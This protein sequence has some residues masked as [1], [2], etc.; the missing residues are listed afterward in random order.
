MNLLPKCSYLHVLLGHLVLQ[1]LD[2]LHHNDQLSILHLSGPLL[3]LLHLLLHLC[4]LR[5]GKPTPKDGPVDQPLLNIQL[6]KQLLEVLLSTIPNK[7]NRLGLLLELALEFLELLLDQRLLP[8]H[9][10]AAVAALFEHQVNGVVPRFIQTVIQLELEASLV[11]AVP[12][13]SK[14]GSRTRSSKHTSSIFNRDP[15]TRVNHMLWMD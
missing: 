9:L 7:V 8:L 2:P 5:L 1:F 10:L 13:D 3:A 14:D 11:F 6:V 12:K 15:K 4:Q